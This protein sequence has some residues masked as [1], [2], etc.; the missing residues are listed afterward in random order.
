MSGAPAPGAAP[1]ADAARGASITARGVSGG[2]VPGRPALTG[3]DFAV[4]AGETVAVL[5]PNAGGK[6]TLFRALLGEL[7]HLEGSVAVEGGLAYMAQTERTR[8]DLPLSA[9]D[10]ALMGA[11]A[12]TPWFK[13]IAGA[14][15]A[16][17]RDALARVGLEAEAREAYGSLSG[18]QRRRVL[19][20]RALV[21]DAQILLLDEPFSGVDAVSAARI[22]EV[23]TSLRAEGR[24]LL[25]AT[26]DV[27]Q[28]RRFDRVLCLHG[29]QIA[30]GAPAEVLTP[31][32]LARTYG[33][34]LILLA[35]GTTAVAVDHH[36]HH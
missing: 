12:R 11:H 22:E 25:V 9:L 30:Y 23:F 19:L 28:S 24:I 2:Y 3:V 26:H 32:V 7:P 1:A 18:G 33:D 14:D 21:Q 15:R 20:A 29:E 16:A 17:A 6:T 10:V 34:E 31:D 36:H 8:L 27:H 5:G 35:D 13:R 4:R